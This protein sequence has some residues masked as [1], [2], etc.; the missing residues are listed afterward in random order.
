[1][2]EAK[3]ETNQGIAA[4]QFSFVGFVVDLLEEVFCHGGHDG[5]RQDVGREH[6]KTDGFSERH[7]QISRYAAEEEHRDEDDA[8]RDG[9]HQRGNRDLRGA[10][11]NG[12]LDGLAFFQIAVDVFDFNSGVVDQ[13]ADG[14]REPTQGHDVDGL[15]EGAQGEQRR[16]NRKR[17]GDG[18]DERAAPAAE[19]DQDHDGGEAGGDDAFTHDAAD[20]GAHEDRLIGERRDLERGGSW[21]LSCRAWRGYQR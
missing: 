2:L 16:K 19:E 18:N 6:G 11:E 8:N 14:Q 15:A 17:D 1:M 9:S 3:L 12:L 4:G 10:V 21:L 7:E 5:A 13:N 20:G